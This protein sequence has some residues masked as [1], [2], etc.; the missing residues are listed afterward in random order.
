MRW[1]SPLKDQARQKELS[2]DRCQVGR[3]LLES[4]EFQY[5]IVGKPW[6]LRCYGKAGIGQGTWCTGDLDIRPSSI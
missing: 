5:W 6:H 1:L 4:E 2:K 3:W